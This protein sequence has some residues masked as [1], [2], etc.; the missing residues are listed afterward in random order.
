MNT[1]N[2][3][4]GL[5]SIER[6]DAITKVDTATQADFNARITY[7]AKQL[8]TPTP[9]VR[10][11][12]STFLSHVNKELAKVV[13]PRIKED[14]ARRGDALQN[15]FNKVFPGPPEPLPPPSPQPTPPIPS[16]LMSPQPKPVVSFGSE[17]VRAPLPSV[18]RKAVTVSESSVLTA[19]REEDE[20]RRI[21]EKSTIPSSTLT[22]T[23]KTKAEDDVQKRCQAYLLSKMGGDSDFCT[24]WFE[25]LVGL[26]YEKDTLVSYIVDPIL[27]PGLQTG[28]TKG[29][30]L[31]GPPGTGKTAL[32]KAIV[33]ELNSKNRIK[34]F[35][36]AP[37]PGELKSQ[38]FGG[39]EQLI[40]EAFSCAGQMAANWSAAN[41]KA[42]RRAK[43][44]SVIFLDEVDTLA[45]SRQ[46]T[47]GESTVFATTTVNA[48]LQAM[49]GI[50]SE[51]SVVVVAATNYLENLDPAFVSRFNVKLKINLPTAES[52][53][54]LLTQVRK[55]RR[56]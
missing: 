55:R 13:T 33:N 39:T 23:G 27:Y 17:S 30:I 3:V 31:Y 12:V 53:E 42:G 19:Q 46:G 32:V 51:Q 24:Y 10:E 25:S 29:I 50:R 36:Y 18:R 16:P 14:M 2:F 22:T 40:Q 47:S 41:T 4:S 37:T 28:K 44:V 26:Q 45:P 35:F 7:L 8:K 48:L 38:Y 21:V 15:E 11:E 9:S 34:V 54:T 20:A 1:Y 56:W 6:M 49:D 5:S 52:I 43:A